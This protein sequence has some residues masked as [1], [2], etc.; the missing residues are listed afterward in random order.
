MIVSPGQD[1][2]FVAHYPNRP[3]EPHHILMLHRESLLEEWRPVDDERYR[4]EFLIDIDRAIDG[5]TAR[6]WPG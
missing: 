4:P 6:G 5:I 1:R 2:P 3:E